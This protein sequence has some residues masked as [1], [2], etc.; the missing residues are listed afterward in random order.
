VL[1]E[2]KDAFLLA[3]GFTTAF[4]TALI[5]VRFFL[6]YVARHTFV[7]FAYYRIGFGTVVLL[8]FW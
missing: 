6:G 7:P 8:Y 2:V 1:I 3:T 4:L 5:V